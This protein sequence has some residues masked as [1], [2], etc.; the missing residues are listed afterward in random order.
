[1][2]TYYSAFRKIDFLC[3]IA[4]RIVQRENCILDG[5][6]CM[7]MFNPAQH[8]DVMGLYFV[9]EQTQPVIC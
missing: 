3:E 9:S 5:I 7:R 2:L 8:T 4:R 6:S 1:M